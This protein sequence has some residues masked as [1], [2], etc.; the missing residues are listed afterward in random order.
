MAQTSWPFESIDTSETQFSM[1]A[2]NIGQGVINDKGFELE[3]FADSSGMN[4]KVKSGQALVRGHYYDSTAQETLTIATA[5]PT[6]PRIDRV[7]L[8]LD[9][10][11][12][13]VVLAVIT[14]TPAG[15]PSAPALTQTVGA[16]Y[17]LP[18]ALV[19]VAAAAATIGPGAVTDQRVIFSPWTGSI[20][21]SQIS[22][23]IAGSK[24]AGSITTA[25]IPGANLT[26][27]V[28]GSLISGSI[29]TGTLPGANITGSITVA[30]IPAGRIVTTT[31]DKSSNYTL[32]AADENSYIRS[33]G[34]AIT[35]TVPDVL[36]NGES[37]NFIQAGAGQITFTGS[38]VTINS[39]DAKLK[40]NKQFSGATITKLGGAY[41]LVG[42]LA[43]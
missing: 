23:T 17:E 35:I 1:W 43:A 31:T 29:T 4:V 2:S 5:D 14:G 22:G 41:Y 32:V 30:T 36:A 21:E 6:N 40:T 3:P 25:T 37:V 27:S 10:S 33:T 39:V 20:T 34:S 12:N 16:I 38:G 15:S 8:R 26:G 42:D 13:S 9:P 18:L 11:V 19:A 28:A 7:V 24:I